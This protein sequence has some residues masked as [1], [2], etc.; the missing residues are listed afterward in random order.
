MTIRPL[1]P[2]DV[3]ALAADLARLPLLQR[4]DRSEPALA[5]DLGQALARGDRMLVEESDGLV[6][7]LCWCLPTGAFGMGGYL[8]LLAVSPGALGRGVG[9]A[10]L[11]AFE[12]EVTRTGRNAFLFVSDFNAGAQ[13]F[14]QRHGYQRVGALPGLVLPDVTELIYWK[15]LR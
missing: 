9:P 15:R 8:K 12:A 2:A 11:A 6:R 4:Y 1:T 13:R 3:P 5:A 7:G 14:Y 10:L